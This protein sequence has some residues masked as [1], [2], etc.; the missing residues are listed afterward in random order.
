[1]VDGKHREVFL[2]GSQRSGPGPVL[3]ALVLSSLKA[4]SPVLS[5]SVSVSHSVVSDSLQACQAPLSMEFSRREYQSELPFHPP[6]DLPN[7]GIEPRSPELWA[8][9]LPLYHLGS[10]VSVNR[11]IL[12]IQLELIES[13]LY[14]PQAEQIVKEQRKQFLTSSPRHNVI[15]LHLLLFVPFLIDF[16]ISML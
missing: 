12:N 7:P 13:I 2:P 14:N 4:A 15:I 16:W 11:E 9:S 5:Q 1:M 8:D 10:S 3:W 6:G